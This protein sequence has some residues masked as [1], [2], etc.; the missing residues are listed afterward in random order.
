[1]SKVLTTKRRAVAV[2]VLILSAYSML[3]YTVTNSITLGVM[4]DM[5]SGLSVIGIPF[6][7]FPIFRSTRTPFVLFGYLLARGVEGLLM[8]I[9]G[10]LIVYPSYEPYRN[11]IYQHIH[12]WFFVAGALFF[13]VLLYQTKVVPRYISVWGIIATVLLLLLTLIKLWAVVPDVLNVLILPIILN[14]LYLSIWLMW[15][16]LDESNEN[17]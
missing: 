4:T 10:I 12:I 6:L 15:K 7:L 13:Y 11:F 3:T 17:R 14:E 1:M 16:G 5:I 2:G 8:L 9:G